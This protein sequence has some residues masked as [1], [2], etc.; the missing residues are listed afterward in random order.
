MNISTEQIKQL[1][2]ETGVSV[3]Q[4]RK[5]LEEAG[6]DME[7]A[8][9]VLKKKSTDIA[10]KK[11]D[12]E[13]HD[14]IV[15]VRKDGEKTAVVV[16]N[17]ETDFVAKNAD[18][19]ALAEAITEKVLRDGKDAAME[20]S[21]EMI[22]PV[23]QKIGENIQLSSVD[24]I[25]GAVVGSY[26]H[27][28]K[29]ASVVVLEGG[30]DTLAKDVAMHITAMKPEYTTKDEVSSDI[31]AKVREMFEEEVS[32][33]D[34]PADIKEKM[35]LGKIDTFFKEKTLTEQSF[36]KNPDITVGRLLAD[37]KASIKHIFNKAL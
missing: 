9:L 1:R 21:K 18:F 4:C 11:A 7:K 13:A 36:I 29:T 6:G 31:L 27:N 15:M 3:M 16:L 22:D 28:G 8:L 17:C 32:Q 20:S 2:E 25:E 5:A 35:L 10:A 33:S 23:I 12:R 14:G 26:V 24:I 34:K 37:A 19:I 30:D